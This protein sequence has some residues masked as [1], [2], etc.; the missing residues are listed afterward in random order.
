M[1][2]PEDQP[3]DGSPLP[4]GTYDVIIFNVDDQFD[5]EVHVVDLTVTAGEYRGMT[6]TLTAPS[7]MGTMVELIG[8][9]GTLTVVGGTPD[10][11]LD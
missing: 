10:L 9:P 3:L 8:M 7:S 5:P 2:D 4:D 1:T 11:V 6:M